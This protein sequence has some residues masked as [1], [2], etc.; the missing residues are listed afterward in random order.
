MKRGAKH[1]LNWPRLPICLFLPPLALSYNPLQPHTGL[2]LGATNPLIL[3]GARHF[4]HIIRL[5]AAPQS[6]S[7]SASNGSSASQNTVGGVFG[8][9]SKTASQSFKD[10]SSTGHGIFSARKRHVNKDRSVLKLA[11]ERMAV[12]DCK[13]SSTHPLCCASARSRQ[14]GSVHSRTEGFPQTRVTTLSLGTFCLT[15]RSW[16]R[17]APRPVHE[18]PHRTLPR[19][20]QSILCDVTPR[21]CVR[22]EGVSWV[23]SGLP[24]RHK[25]SV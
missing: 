5:S 9:L 21:R 12:G 15:S 13:E 20:P 4:P 17:C 22:D 8:A 10:A 23:S 7:D 16:G 1:Q 25:E 2:L 11:T 3:S 14:L 18:H 6:S 24:C 19:S